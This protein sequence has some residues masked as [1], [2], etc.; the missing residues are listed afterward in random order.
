[1]R[2]SVIPFNTIVEY[3]NLTSFVFVTPIFRTALLN[4]LNQHD[5]TMLSQQS[6]HIVDCYEVQRYF[7]NYCLV[8]VTIV[9]LFSTPNSGGSQGDSL[10]GS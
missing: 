1:M 9:T 8:A 5:N 3:L 2:F 4:V 6:Q 10:R 7:S